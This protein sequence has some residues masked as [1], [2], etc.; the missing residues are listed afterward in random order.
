M[1]SLVLIKSVLKIVLNLLVYISIAHSSFAQEGAYLVSRHN[2]ESNS[3]VYF[4]FKLS[5]DGSVFIASRNGIVV[6]SGEIADLIDVGGAILSLTISENQEI[7]FGGYNGIGILEGNEG[8]WLFQQEGVVVF[9]LLLHAEYLF[10][11]SANKLF[12][13]DLSVGTTKSIEDQYAGHFNAMFELNGEI[14]I[15]SDNKGVLQLQ[16]DKLIT[17]ALDKLQELDISFVVKSKSGDKHLIGTFNDGVYLYQNDLVPLSNEYLD[18]EVIA[19]GMWLDEDRL[20]LGSAYSGLLIQNIR[21]STTTLI[22]HKSGLSPEGVKAISVDKNG[23]ILSLTDSD[24]ELIA[25]N[26]PIRNF[27]HYDKLEGVPS[28][29]SLFKDSLYVSTDRG[30]YKLSN[31]NNYEERSYTVNRQRKLPIKTYQPSTR[32]G[33]FR[34]KSKKEEVVETAVVIDKAV[35][36]ENVFVSK[37][38]EYVKIP[39]ISQI[40]QFIELG[41]EMLVAGQSGVF[42]VNDSSV[43]RI[44]SLSTDY[45]F[46][47][48]QENLLFICGEGQVQSFTKRNDRWVKNQILSDFR[49]DI[50]HIIEYEGNYWLCGIN[51]VHKLQIENEQLIDA[52]IYILDNP[53]F[54]KIYGLVDEAGIKFISKNRQYLLRSDSLSDQ[55][56]KG[57][58]IILDNNNVVWYKKDDKWYHEN[59]ENEHAVLTALSD[60]KKIYHSKNKGVSWV[61]TSSNDILHFNNSYR[62][63]SDKYIPYLHSVYNQQQELKDHELSVIEQQNSQLAF[64]VAHPDLTNLQKTHYRYR[65][66]GL[67]R[68]WSDWSN[69][70]LFEFSFLPPNKYRLEVEAKTAFGNIYTLDPISFKVE[71]P[72]WKKPIFYVFE[73]MVIMLLLVLSVKLRQF[74]TKFKLIS[75][76]LAFLVLAIV[77]EGVEAILGSFFNLDSSPFF[78]FGLQ[79]ITALILFP[80]EGLLR[81]YI[82]ERPVSLSKV[83]KKRA[84]DSM[85]S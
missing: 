58:N 69:N 38:T 1:K 56:F 72:Y 78:G 7:Y 13:Y 70:S 24:L 21:D 10:A 53:Y 84:E 74:G 5:E 18:E 55:D 4:D 40:D 31:I 52:K 6:Y 50:S 44:V 65:L 85:K 62:S 17:P 26:V 59:E 47:N 15:S 19:C 2:P 73:I 12:V 68:E 46:I 41:D 32:K 29:L 39:K 71:P 63:G 14:Y 76:L 45:I 25:Y 11:L 49:D 42:K 83:L 33:L 66:I 36:T 34:N 57:E 64:R 28:G 22:D 3:N 48:Q 75:T 35:V 61:I 27:V 60:V 81:K 23:N 30:L 54:N 80:F 79:V 43:E 16:D 9:D 77:I 37:S 51:N 20:L 82:L 8:K 67:D